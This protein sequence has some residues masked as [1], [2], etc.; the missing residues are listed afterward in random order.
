MTSSGAEQID[1]T[2]ARRRLWEFFDGE[3]TA[4]RAAEVQEHLRVCAHCFQISNL[5][6]IFL[7][8]LSATRE[9]VTVPDD[10]RERVLKLL[11]DEGLT[12]EQ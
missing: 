12:P 5:E 7:E 8:G 2:E 9:T 4:E 6:R 10:L 3:L 1:C 11:R